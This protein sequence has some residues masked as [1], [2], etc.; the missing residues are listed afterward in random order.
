M[1]NVQ[2]YRLYL[3]TL[4]QRQKD[5]LD[6]CDNTTFISIMSIKYTMYKIK[7]YKTGYE[8]YQSTKLQY[9]LNFTLYAY[10]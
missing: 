1:H 8:I 2:Y 10:I 4:F 5:R 3:I 7:V 6:M 9:H